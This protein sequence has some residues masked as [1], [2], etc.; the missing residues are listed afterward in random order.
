MSIPRRLF[1]KQIGLSTLALSLGACQ[2]K[3]TQKPNIIFIMADDLGYGHLGC[4]GQKIIKTPHIDKLAQEGRKFTQAYSGCCVCAPARSTLMTGLHAGHTSVRGNGGGVSLL[5][6]DVTVAQILKK[7]GYTTGLFGKWGLGEAGT[8]GVPNKKGFDEFFGYLHQLHAQFYYPEFLWHNEEKYPIPENANMA[9]K[10]YSHDLIMDRALDFVRDNKNNPFFLYLPVTIPHH[11]F[12]A[13]E[14]TL[15]MYS[16]QFD[17]NP[18]PHWR[19]G[20]ALPKEPKATMAA[21]ITH[22][23]KGVGKLMELLKKLN[24]DNNTIVIFTSDNGPADGPLENVEFFDANG[25]LW[26]AKRYLYEGGL[27]IPFIVR[28]PGKVKQSSICH[29]LTYFPDMMPTFLELAGAQHLIPQ[30][31]DGLSIVPSILQKGEQQE[32][33]Y[34]YWEDSDYDRIAPYGLK[35]GSLQQAVRLG[36]WKAVKNSPDADIELYNLLEDLGE[37]NNVAAQHPDV[38]TKMQDI[39]ARSHKDAPPQVD[40]TA[41]EAR[42]LYVPGFTS[43]Q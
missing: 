9:N 38:V 11:E 17:E 33:D 24:L 23:D 43:R 42:S 12:V 20:Y 8:V 5:P 40:M 25:P 27:R 18:I 32:H 37:E 6:E 26:G 16:G 21:M 3:K 35:P 31:I 41:V 14:E 15:K 7:A 39:M 28:W 10:V 1:L 22:M 4:Y 30:N 34:L 2:V 36:D 19:D 29:N 13:P